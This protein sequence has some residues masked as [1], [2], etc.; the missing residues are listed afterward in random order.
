LNR[1][2]AVGALLWID[3]P[4]D[5]SADP[6]LVAVVCVNVDEVWVRLDGPGSS[7]DCGYFGLVLGLLRFPSITYCTMDLM[8]NSSQKLCGLLD[9]VLTILTS[10]EWDLVHGCLQGSHGSLLLLSR[11]SLILVR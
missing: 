4:S 7:Q 9:L 11:L 8:L 5:H 1:V 2:P 3:L 10:C 6:V